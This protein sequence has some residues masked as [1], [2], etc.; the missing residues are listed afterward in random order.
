MNFFISFSIDLAI[1]SYGVV[2]M[3]GQGLWCYLGFGSRFHGEI[4]ASM[5][6]ILSGW[7]LDESRDVNSS[8][9]FHDHIVELGGGLLFST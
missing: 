7:F 3:A 4:Y 5:P 1:L 6:S 8:Q 9:N 2:F